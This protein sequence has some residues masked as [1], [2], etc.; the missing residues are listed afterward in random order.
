MIHPNIEQAPTKDDI[1]PSNTISASILLSPDH[2]VTSFAVPSVGLAGV[3]LTAAES[4]SNYDRTCPM[5]LN[6][7]LSYNWCPPLSYTH[8][9]TEMSATD[10]YGIFA[11]ENSSAYIP[12][13]DRNHY[14]GVHPHRPVRQGD[15]ERMSHRLRMLQLMEEALDVTSSSD[16]QES[17]AVRYDVVRSNRNCNVAPQ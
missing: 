3:S 16:Q 17:D 7:L 4:V 9:N 13:I 12:S 2:V 10:A 5:T 11:T 8:G 14:F 1:P 6:H 15:E